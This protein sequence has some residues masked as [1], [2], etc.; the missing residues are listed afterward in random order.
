MR[1]LIFIPPNEFKDESVSIVKLF[2]DKW[3]ID[4]KL[5]SYTAKDCKG[6]HGAVYRPDI[7]TSKA[8]STEYDGIIL[9]DGEGIEHYKIYDFRPLLDLII[10][11]NNSRKYIVAVNNAVKIPARANVIRGKRVSAHDKETLRLVTLFHGVPENDPYTLSGNLITI[12]RSEDIEDS[13][14]KILEHMGVT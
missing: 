3:G 1:F 8:S 10:N 14:Q 11:F 7:H 13:M 5:T 9:I 2:F 12:G 6:S 4:Y